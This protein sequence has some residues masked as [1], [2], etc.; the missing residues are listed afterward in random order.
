MAEVRLNC[1]QRMVVIDEFE[2]ARVTKHMGMDRT[3]QLPPKTRVQK[4]YVND[5]RISLF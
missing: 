3:A 5:G 2:A 1:P 4:V